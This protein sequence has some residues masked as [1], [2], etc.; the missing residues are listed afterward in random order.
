MDGAGKPFDFLAL[1]HLCWLWILVE[2]SRKYLMLDFIPA[3]RRDELIADDE[4]MR[5][6]R[7]LLR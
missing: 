1:L 7:A 2:R 5:Q 3:K 6:R 4:A